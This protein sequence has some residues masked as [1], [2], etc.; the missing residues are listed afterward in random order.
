MN[1]TAACTLIPRSSGKVQGLGKGNSPHA[2]VCVPVAAGRYVALG[3][4]R[5]QTIAGFAG[6]SVEIALSS[7][8]Q[9][10]NV[11]A[12]FGSG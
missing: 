11:H 8:R 5:L 12:C 10:W 9:P 7:S 2:Q 6:H 1:P 3:N 4:D